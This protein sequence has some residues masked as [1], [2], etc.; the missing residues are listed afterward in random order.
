VPGVTVKDYMHNSYYTLLIGQ[1][2]RVYYLGNDTYAISGNYPGTFHASEPALITQLDFPVKKLFHNGCFN[3]DVAGCITQDNRLIVWGS[4]VGW[5]VEFWDPAHDQETNNFSDITDGLPD[6]EI[7]DFSICWEGFLATLANGEVWRVESWD[8][9]Y[10]WE[11]IE[12]L[13]PMQWYRHSQS[14]M[15]GLDLDGYLWTERADYGTLL[16]WPNYAYEPTQSETKW[17]WKT[18]RYNRYNVCW[19]GVDVY[20]RL[21]TW[22]RQSWGPHL[23]NGTIGNLAWL[24]SSYSGLTQE[25]YGEMWESFFPQ[26]ARYDA[27]EMIVND[28][29]DILFAAVPRPYER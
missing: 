5:L 22:G 13:P 9:P 20:G 24:A 23:G 3:Y 19:Q 7:V 12:A 15:Y 2:D 16:E 4:G 1:D 8:T 26:S 11:R 29:Y 25:V 21:L 14:A 18:V 6:E 28:I 17:K 27:G 10:Q